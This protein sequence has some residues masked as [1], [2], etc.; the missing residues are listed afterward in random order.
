MRELA[1]LTKVNAGYV[2]RVVAYLDTEALATRYRRLLSDSRPV[3]AAKAG[4]DLLR[5][6]FP[7][8]RGVGAEMAIRSAGALADPDEIAAS[9]MALTNDLLE[10]L[11]S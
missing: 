5:R 4:L 3:E 7:T 1:A 10:A 6:Q 8:R 11:K 2:S 9:C